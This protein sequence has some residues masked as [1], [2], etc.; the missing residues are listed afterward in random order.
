MIAVVTQFAFLILALATVASVV[1]AVYTY[2]RNGQAQLQLSALGLLQHYL[3]LAVEHPDLAS[4]GD[5]RPVDARYAWFAV[6]ALN[7]AQTLWLLAGQEP[8]WQRAINAIIRQHRPF[9]LSG[10]FAGDDFNPA[11]VAFLR[12]QIPG[13]RSVGD[14][15]QH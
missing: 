10:A 2:R 4:P 1:F 14:P 7:T 8:D 13:V 5:D 12:R 11:F 15:E 6:H 3:D 9:L